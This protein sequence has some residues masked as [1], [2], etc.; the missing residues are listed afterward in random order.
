[1]IR[2]VLG[3]V[4]LALGLY[5]LAGAVGYLAAVGGISALRVDSTTPRGDCVPAVLPVLAVSCISAWV[6]T[7]L[8]IGPLADG[9]WTLVRRRQSAAS[10]FFFAVFGALVIAVFLA[11]L[12]IGSFREETAWP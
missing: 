11:N 10:G 7:A 3:R 5:L 6:A 4:A 8:W 2:R 1:M 12:F 9:I